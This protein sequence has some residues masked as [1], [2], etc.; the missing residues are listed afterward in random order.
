MKGILEE[1]HLYGKINRLL[2]NRYVPRWV[3][4]TFDVFIVMSAF[5]LSYNL[6]YNFASSQLN[7]LDEFR[8]MVPVMIAYIAGFIIFR[9]FA[10]IIRHTTSHD[11]QRIFFLVLFSSILLVAISLSSRKYYHFEFLHIPISVILIHMM[12]T[13]T[14]LTLSR[15]IIKY[16]YQSLSISQSNGR[17][18]RNPQMPRLPGKGDARMPAQLLSRMHHASR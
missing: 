14:L 12:V 9:P 8:Q 15:I 13:A 17:H 2:K 3:I 5:I 18:R 11:I 1:S 6:R 16:V 4:F 7:T 10:G